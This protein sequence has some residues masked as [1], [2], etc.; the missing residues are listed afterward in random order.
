M[1]A[2]KSPPLIRAASTRTSYPAPGNG[3]V[4]PAQEIPV[5]APEPIVM[6]PS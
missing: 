5:R 4:A 1:P 2:K 3:S 6:T